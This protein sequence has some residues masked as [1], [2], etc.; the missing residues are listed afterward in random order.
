MNPLNK[1]NA[2]FRRF[3]IDYLRMA[4]PNSKE[5]TQEDIKWM[6]EQGVGTFMF[7]HEAPDLL[8]QIVVQMLARLIDEPE[9][10]THDADAGLLFVMISPYWDDEWTVNQF[11]ERAEFFRTREQCTGMIYATLSLCECFWVSNWS[12]VPYTVKFW[13]ERSATL[14]S[15]D[16]TLQ[17]EK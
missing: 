5:L 10:Y 9:A 11:L 3:T 4:F 17:S 7:P 16:D 12:N 14:P 13:L 1:L 8:P 6:L 2:D 15:M